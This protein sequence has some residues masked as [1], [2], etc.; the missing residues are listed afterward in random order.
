MIAKGNRGHIHVINTALNKYFVN[1]SNDILNFTANLVNTDQHEVTANVI[2]ASQDKSISDSTI[3]YDDGL[4]GDSLANDNFWGALI[5]SISEE[6][7]FNVSTSTLDKQTGE[8]FYQP[9]LTRFTTA[10]PIKLDSVRLVKGITNYYNLR[11]FVR[12]EGNS[13][14]IS[15]AKIQVK[16]NDPWVTSIAG[17]IS[18][19]SLAAGTSGGASSW[20]AVT[21]V[22]S[23]FPGYFN[24]KAEMS[25]DGWTYWV[26]SIRVNVITGVKED[27]QRPLSFILEQNYPNP[28]NPSTKISWQSPVSSW[29]TLKVYYVLGN[30]VIKLVDEY[31]EAGNYEVEFDG[32]NL[33][34]GI[35]F[36]QLKVGGFIETKKMILLR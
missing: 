14:T 2:Y 3:L 28:F 33:A 29:Q 12:N 30:E 6:N 18:L 9:N 24:L 4:H 32:S 25:V 11:P 5:Q 15:N 36:Y 13:L 20:I 31:R 35:Y 10:G 27:L 34:S 8:Y 1:K 19:P 21:F 16:C 7:Y 23:I 17:A 22:E 26:D